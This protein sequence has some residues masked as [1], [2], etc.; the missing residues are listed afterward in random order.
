MHPFP[1]LA[2]DIHDNRKDP[3]DSKETLTFKLYLMM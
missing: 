1:Y 3:D 2:G